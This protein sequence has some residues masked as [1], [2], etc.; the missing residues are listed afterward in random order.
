MTLQLIKRFPE[1]DAIFGVEPDASS[2]SYFWAADWLLRQP[3]PTE[4]SAV[5][6]RHWPVSGW[7]IDAEFPRH[8]PL[9]PSLS[10]QTDLGDSIMTAIVLAPFA[11]HPVRF[12]ELSRL[13]LQECERVQALETE[14]RRMGGLAHDLGRTPASPLPG[15]PEE[16]LEVKPSPLHGATI[17][18]YQ[19]HRMAMCFSIL[20]LKVPGVHIHNPACVIKT[21]PTFF[22]KLAAPP[23]HGL[24][25]TLRNPANG[26]ILDLE[27]TLS[28]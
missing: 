1:R 18:T 11:P 7:Q 5:T 25:A 21:F 2:G 4:G 15:S 24:G 13:R 19:D 16:T 22:H 12:T 27:T 17:Q 10:R 23:P 3:G 14:L 20:G 9:P 6:V 26:N 8:L 28:P